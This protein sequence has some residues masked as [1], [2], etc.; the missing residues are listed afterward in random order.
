[1]LFSGLWITALAVE[2]WKLKKEY[3]HRDA[4]ID[5]QSILF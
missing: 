5:R 2:I 1:M 4:L 3:M